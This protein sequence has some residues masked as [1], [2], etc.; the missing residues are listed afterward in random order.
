MVSTWNITLSQTRL[1]RPD[2]RTIKFEGSAVDQ[3]VNRSPL[4]SRPLSERLGLLG[5][6]Y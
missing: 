5:C 6:N 1:K 4:F 2:E 3:K